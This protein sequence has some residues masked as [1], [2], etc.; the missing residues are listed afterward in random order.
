[1]SVQGVQAL[2][3]RTHEARVL[4]VLRE[5]GA[6]SRG[7]IATAAGLSRTTLSEI[8]GDLLSRGAVVVVDTDHHRRAGSGRP[9]ELLTLDP[10]SG[11]FLGVDIGHTRV[12]IAVAD[13]AHD[14]IAAG[15]AK[16]GP[17]LDR[18][19]RVEVAFALIDRVAARTGVSFRALQG[20]GVGVAGPWPAAPD[21]AGMFGERFGAPVIVDNNTRFAGLAEAITDGPD[22]HDVMYVRLSDGIGGGLVVGGRLVA[23]AGGAAGEFGHV[24]A[25]PGGDP[26]RCGKRGCLETVASIPAVLRS[27]ARRGLALATVQELE[28][29]LG[30]GAPVAAEVLDAATAAVGRVVAV[31]ALVLN[32]AQIVIGG[33]LPRSAPAFVRR[34]EETVAG[35]LCPAG[36]PRP[37]IRAA[38]LGD[39]DG[40]LGAIAALFRQTP[41]LDGYPEPV[42]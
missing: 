42:R 28:A 19:Q 41:L 39:G 37:A 12:R 17:D 34:V 29:A 3:R 27:C 8:T 4:R 20:V 21:L 13:A 25:Q 10:S 5:H 40:A 1:M 18:G 2:V 26:C 23:G 11:Q 31:A 32:P 22:V 14:I 7:Q 36:G 30:R 9:A 15:H 33:R 35:E 16:Y 6:L 24:T 38:R